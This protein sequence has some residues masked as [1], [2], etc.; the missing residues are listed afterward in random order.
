MLIYSSNVKGGDCLNKKV[1][2]TLASMS[3]IF[4]APIAQAKGEELETEINPKSKEVML[5]WND[6]GDRYEVYSEGK[7]VWKGTE[8]NYIQKDLSPSS[9]QKYDIVAYKAGKKVDTINVDTRTL[10]EKQ[11][12]I[13]NVSDEEAPNPLQSDG[14]ID[15]T[16]NDNVL[17]L[18]L[19]GNVQDDFDGKLEVYKDEKLLDDDAEE[20]FVDEDVKPGEI[21][22]YKFV[23]LEK[24]SESEIEQVNKEFE[25]R[26]ETIRFDQMKDYYFRPHEYIKAIKIPEQNEKVN[27]LAWEPPVGPHP[28][29]TGIMY[30]TFIPDKLVPAKS[31]WSG[32]V[33]SDKFGGDNRSF[34]FSGG[35]HRTQVEAVARFTS[36]GSTTY[37]RKHVGLTKLYDKN[38]KFKKQKRASSK[39]ITLQQGNKNKSQNYFLINHNAKVAFNDFGWVTP[40]ITYTVGV[41]VYKNGRLTATG[42]RDQAPSHEM[43]AYIPYSDAMVPLFKANNKGFEYL[44][45]P[46]PNARINVSI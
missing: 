33:G 5:D 29:Q 32:L 40:G 19:R 41:V 15:S 21:Y 30:R 4:T 34:S 28:N 26:G 3:L 20:T 35:S 46:M 12:A 37:F 45:P 38:G 13:K 7:L 1:L 22:V 27:S 25:K 8:S 17:T 6:V 24:L 11:A 23:A 39:D 10:P 42:S 36:S 2:I 44:A 14:Y 9:P 43:Y 18:K 16:I 31:I